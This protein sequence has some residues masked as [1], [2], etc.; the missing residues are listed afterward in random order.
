MWSDNALDE[1]A[2]PCAG[3]ITL[4]NAHGSVQA[5]HVNNTVRLEE[6]T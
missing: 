6:V 1:R 5:I 2:T 4:I 3:D